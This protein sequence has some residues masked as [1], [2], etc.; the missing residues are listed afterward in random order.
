MRDKFLNFDVLFFFIILGFSLLFRVTNLDLIEFKTD[1]AVNLLLAARPALGHSLPPG[2]TVSSIGIL[3][4]ALFNYIISPLTFFTLD[5]RAFSFLVGLI[6]SLAI[7]LFYFVVK[8]YYGKITAFVSSILFCLSP[9]AIL[10]SRKI[11]TQ[12]LLI[13]FF[14]LM[15]YSLHKIIKEKKQIFWIPFTFSSLLLI[16]LHQA[17]LFFIALVVIILVFEKVKINFKYILIGAL[18]GIIPLLPYFNYEV[19]NGYP[20]FKAL[21]ITSQRLKSDRSL[22]IFLRPLQITS[23]GDFSFIMGQSLDAFAKK[24]PIANSLRKIFY[25][26]YILV[27][28]GAFLY[29]RKFKSL[30]SLGLAAVFLPFVYFLLKIETFM[31]YYIIVLPLL[32]LFLGISFEFLF[33]RKSKLLKIASLTLF[34]SLVVT[35]FVFDF[36]FFKLLSQ[37]G[38][39]QGDY[40]STLKNSENDIKYKKHNELFLFRFIPLNYAFGYNPFAKMV[41]ADVSLEKIPSLEKQLQKSDDPRVKQ[42]ILAFYTK[43]PPTLETLDILRKKLRDIPQYNT[44]YTETLDDY[45][46]RNYKKEYVSE[47]FDLRLFYPQHWNIK[48]DADKLTLKGDYVY[49]EIVKGNEIIKSSNN[50]YRESQTEILGNSFK[51]IECKEKNGKFC[52]EF[53]KGESMILAISV[54]PLNFSP[55]KVGADL[56]AAEEIIKTL[57]FSNQ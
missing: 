53:Y 9:W 1:E 28:F 11:W 12:D 57:R 36:S 35:S 54:F 25:I 52:G 43:N 27:I 20:D 31:H 26:E 39:L 48:E 13:P 10:Y 32:F 33:N 14:I 21:F 23:Q 2:G 19:K 55:D 18:L 46:S 16:Q 41:Y 49:I 44:I 17:S 50:S 24:F 37:Q 4:P 42:E 3:N 22:E 8:K 7:I 56:K 15:F 34:L 6:N 29:I 51:K 47:N 38:Y 40:G 30:R 5:P 45:L